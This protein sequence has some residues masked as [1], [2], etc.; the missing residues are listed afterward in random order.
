MFASQGISVCKRIVRPCTTQ[1]AV[2]CLSVTARRE[3]CSYLFK[4]N[5]NQSSRKETNEGTAQLFQ[6]KCKNVATYVEA[7]EC[8]NLAGIQK[9]AGRGG[10]IKSVNCSS[11]AE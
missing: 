2:H 10:G 5:A 4:L 6:T 11:N 8:G 7:W 3:N 9:H 1:C